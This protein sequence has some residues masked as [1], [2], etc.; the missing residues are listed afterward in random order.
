L[1]A[2]YLMKSGNNTDTGK[3]ELLLSA[4][5]QDI[6]DCFR[7]CYDDLYRLGLF[8]YK[9]PELVKESIHLL[10]IELWKIRERLPGVTSI[11]EYVLT[12]F[13]RILYKQ[14]TGSVKHWSTIT[15][16]IE[17]GVNTDELYT[18][19]YEEMMINAQE[20]NLVRNRLLT[21]LPLLA[22]R[23]REL[24]R[25]RYFEE[26]TIEEIAALTAL[27]PRTIYNTLHNA[28]GRLRELLA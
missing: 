2:A 15:D 12:I 6:F 18:D 10:Y 24:I 14:K 7:L 3:W 11:K 17:N 28:L 22:E 4:N 21:A 20:D 26:K 16:F 13:K 19:S 25:M 8:L 5:E 9:D 1:I 27:T 23:Q